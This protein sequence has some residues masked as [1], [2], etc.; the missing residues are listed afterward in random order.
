MSLISEYL[1]KTA[2]L[3]KERQREL[4]PPV[5]LRGKKRDSTIS[6]IKI[7]SIALS[8]LLAALCALFIFKPPFS[9]SQNNNVFVTGTSLP[10]PSAIANP[11]S[12]LDNIPSSQKL[13]TVKKENIEHGP[14]HAPSVQ[15]K[16]PSTSA[17]KPRSENIL[18]ASSQDLRPVEHV[19]DGHAQ[20]SVPAYVEKTSTAIPEFSKSFDIF[21][22]RS[23]ETLFKAESSLNSSASPGKNSDGITENDS[24]KP[25][26]SAPQADYKAYFNLALSA[27]KAGD[28]SNAFR[29]YKKTIAQ[30]P[31]FSK[32]LVNL[33]ALYIENGEDDKAK[34]ILDMLLEKEPQNID[35]NV[36]MGIFFLKKGDYEKAEKMLLNAFEGD[37]NNITV[38]VNL[39]Y[40]NEIQNR[41]EQALKY[42]EHIL[43][44]DQDNA[45]ALLSAAHILEKEK[46]YQHAL[47]YYRKSLDTKE[48]S[49]SQNFTMKIMNRMR[50]LQDR[51]AKNK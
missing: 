47:Q 21:Q 35:A 31:E 37:K 5:L 20:D 2:P 30:N 22:T 1:K 8:F 14:A 28:R 16:E 15:S 25:E 27:H 9:K 13:T 40:L 36:N 19:T 51:L 18:T 49:K 26:P 3:I 29:Y 24:S 33:A 39:A 45:R 46:K 6:R 11:A 43:V 10:A 12:K 17:P 44:N 42:Y 4:I 50:L 48:V 23:M 7:S 41:M 38:L 32:A 34:M